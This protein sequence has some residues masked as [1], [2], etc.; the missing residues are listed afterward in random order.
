MHRIWRAIRPV[1]RV[2]VAELSDHERSWGWD[3]VVKTAKRVA[4]KVSEGAEGEEKIHNQYHIEGTRPGAKV[5]KLV[6]KQ[7]QRV[8]EK[9][10]WARNHQRRSVKLSMLIFYK[11]W[12]P[13]DPP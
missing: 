5:K 6:Q 10:Y 3:K 1:Q 11:S 12:E 4:I 8:W 2:A 13:P 9:S 7:I